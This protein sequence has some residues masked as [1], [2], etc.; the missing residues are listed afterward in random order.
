LCDSILGF[1]AFIEIRGR[2]GGNW[3]NFLKLYTSTRRE[4]QD[5]TWPVEWLHEVCT[6][7]KCKKP[8]AMWQQDPVPQADQRNGQNRAPIGS[9]QTGTNRK[10]CEWIKNW[11]P[12]AQMFLPIAWAVIYAPPGKDST[13]YCLAGLQCHHEIQNPFDT[14]CLPGFRLTFCQSILTQVAAIELDRIC[15]NLW[16]RVVAEFVWNSF[17]PLGLLLWPPALKS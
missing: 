17:G 16:N 11:L 3:Y 13:W 6:S 5:W 15:G 12:P 8:L 9:R 4:I 10:I 7:A 2:L 1:G 14:S